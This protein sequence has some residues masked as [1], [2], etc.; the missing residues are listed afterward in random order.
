[1]IPL[2]RNETADSR[3]EASIPRSRGNALETRAI[4]RQPNH[5]SLNLR[6]QSAIFGRA[7]N[8]DLPSFTRTDATSQNERKKS[9]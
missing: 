2:L 8:H 5:I 6:T 3:S 9:I 4:K 7:M 1:M